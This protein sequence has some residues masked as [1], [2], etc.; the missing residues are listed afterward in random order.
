MRENQDHV[1]NISDNANVKKLVY[2]LVF[3]VGGISKF[4]RVKN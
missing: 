1:K 3:F 2:R 4:C